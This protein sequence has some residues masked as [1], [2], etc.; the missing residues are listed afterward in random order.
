M[1][2]TFFQTL[3]YIDLKAIVDKISGGCTSVDRL[4]LDLTGGRKEMSSYLMLCAQLLCSEQ[5]ELYHVETNDPQ[6]PL[7]NPRHPESAT[8]YYPKTPDEIS[9]IPVPFVRLES[10]FQV[11]GKAG[12]NSL[13]AYLDRGKKALESLSLAGLVSSG[14]DHEI[15]SPLRTAYERAPEIRDTWEEIEGICR[16]FLGILKPEK[17]Q[18]RPILLREAVEQIERTVSRRMDDMTLSHKVGEV[19]VLGDKV[20]IQRIFWILVKNARHHVDATE[21]GITAHIDGEKVV[22]AFQNNGKP[23]EAHV[24]REAFQPFKSY[25]AP[26]EGKQIGLPTVKALVVAL[27]A[28]IEIVQSDEKGTVFYLTFPK[29]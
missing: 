13:W 14:I 2:L 9:L 24:R 20:L 1:C 17:L 23:M 4:F 15:A 21:I 10:L 6:G 27:G 26:Q 11:M 12:E 3:K 25:A 16:S 7:F 5:D 19:K 28:D 29:G 18:R 8:Y 22:V